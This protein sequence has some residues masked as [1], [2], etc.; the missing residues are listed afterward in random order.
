LFSSGVAV[1]V[2]VAADAHVLHRRQADDVVD[3]IEEV[4]DGCRLL[5][6][7]EHSNAGDPHHPAR[8]RHLLDGFVRLASW[9]SWHQ[10]PAVRVRDENR[11]PA[12]LEGVERRAVAAVRHVDG[13][14]SLVHALD[15]GHAEVRQALVTPLGRAVADQVP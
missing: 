9:M 15:D 8:R 11:T 13:H 4:L 12:C 5:D 1:E 10:R 14:S 7:D 2:Y 6:A 3:V